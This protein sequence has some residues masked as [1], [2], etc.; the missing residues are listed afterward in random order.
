MKITTIN[1][2]WLVIG[3]LGT[4]KSINNIV[5]QITEGTLGNRNHIDYTLMGFYDSAHYSS[6]FHHE[7]VGRSYRYNGQHT[8]P[9]KSPCD[10]FML[11]S[12]ALDKPLSIQHA[13]ESILKDSEKKI[14]SHHN[15]DPE[16]RMMWSAIIITSFCE[17]P[18]RTN[19]QESVRIAD[20]LKQKGIK[21]V[22]LAHDTSG[23]KKDKAFAQALRSMK[24]AAHEVGGVCAVIN[25]SKPGIMSEVLYSARN[26]LV[27]K[28]PTTTEREVKDI[29]LSK[30]GDKFANQC[31]K[32]F[33]GFQPQ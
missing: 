23:D 17:K 21:V 20:Q 10:S 12:S 18:W 14:I 1:H 33:K 11:K 31:R 2:A 28:L 26:V 29:A 4:E 22:F 19:S 5:G 6:P 32:A 15:R 9:S 27:G 24:R 30:M 25:P 7:E 8:N 13:L 16:I 3:S